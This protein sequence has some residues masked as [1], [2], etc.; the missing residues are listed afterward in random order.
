MGEQVTSDASKGLVVTRSDDQFQR[1]HVLIVTDD[2]D[3]GSFLSEG[4]VI[5]GFWA[6]VIASGLQTIEVLRLRTFD[7]AIV[8]LALSGLG[9]LETIRRV[10]TASSLVDRRVDLPILA[11]ADRADQLGDL[12]P[13]AAGIDRLL[14]PPIEIEQL[15]PAL[16]RVVREWR[17]AHPGRE[18]ADRLAQQKDTALESG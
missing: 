10:R 9:A 13:A 15:V 3:L 17:L 1:P 16:F 14:L 2:P 6:S 12:S 8:D 11:V 5:G 18:W 7:L 4:L